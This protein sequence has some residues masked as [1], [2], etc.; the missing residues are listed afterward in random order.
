MCKKYIS[1]ELGR[2]RLLL[3]IFLC[4]VC[5]CT[6]ASIET[7]NQEPDKRVRVDL[8]YADEAVADRNL[9]PDIQV[10][11]GSVKLRH[12]SMYMFCDSALI[13]ESSNSV[14]AFGNVK[15]EQGD[16]LFIYGD[17]LYYDGMSQ[18]AKLR[19]NVR[20]INKETQLSTDS[21]NYD[22]VEGLG[23]YFDGGTLTDDQNTLTS[24]EGEYN[25][26]S[27]VA[28]FNNDVVLVNTDFTL[29]SDQLTYST[30]TKM[31]LIDSPAD[32]VNDDTHIHTTSGRY[33]TDS[34][35]AELLQRSVITNEGKD[36]TG[37]SLFYNRIAGFGEAFGN[38]ILNDTANKNILKGD[39]CY[40]DEK[41][42]NAFATKRALAIDYSQGDSLFLHADTLRLLTYNVSTD[43]VQRE[44]RAYNKVRAYRSDV[45]AVCDSLVF[46]TTDSCMTMY[47]NPVL[48][49]GPEQLLGEEIRV[50][51]NDSTIEWA[52]IVNQ[53]LAIEEYDSLHYNQVT[54]KE[55]KAFFEE[56][57][58]RE[59][60]VNGNV[61]VVYYPVEEKDSS[62]ILMNYSE[63]SL[64]KMFLRDRKM[65]KGL[66]V[67]KTTGT[68]YPLDQIP[69]GK[70]KLGPFI[71]L[72]N[73]RPR[74][75]DDI[76][77]WKEREKG[78]ELQVIDRGPAVKPRQINVKHKNNQR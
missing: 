77:D 16:T 1:I 31:A 73:I 59:V 19:E 25:V 37:D 54:G 45:Q 57:E 10:L 41:G 18:L 15:M 4:F 67:G 71:W 30:A 58:M 6:M 55:M 26:S 51:M 27:K 12:D 78:Q 61:L 63:G 39:Y 46:H 44:M 48:W 21:L 2:Q 52:H 42:Q 32:I 47:H 24:E 50:Y 72:D 62:L 17:Y 69:S 74:D 22:R 9:R 40:Y 34:E 56:G 65:D 33:Y 20:L 5:L 28:I 68:A 36:L 60:E 49:H 53:A 43:S 3:V 8:L 76:F 11:R 35:Q 70:D 38:V 13:Y 64:L 75:K 7:N 14:E 66:F 29:T 23:Y